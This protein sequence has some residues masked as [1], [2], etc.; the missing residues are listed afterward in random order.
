[1]DKKLNR[2]V[3]YIKTKGDAIPAKPSKEV[4][5]ALKDSVQFVE[6]LDKVIETTDNLLNLLTEIEKKEKKILKWINTH[7]KFK[8]SAMCVELGID[9]GNFQRMLKKEKFS[10]TSEQLVKIEEKLKEY[11]YGK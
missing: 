6:K 9:K 7:K 2:Q 8:W 10:L 11:G 3:A 1:M 5:Q 4:K